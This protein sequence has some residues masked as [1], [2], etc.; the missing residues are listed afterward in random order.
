MSDFKGKKSQRLQVAGKSAEQTSADLHESVQNNIEVAKERIKR[1]RQI[2]ADS[3][4]IIMRVR[5]ALAQ[6]ERLRLNMV[7]QYPANPII[8]SKDNFGE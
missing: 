4:E 6:S 5:E 7:L 2:A 1:S 3:R 8:F